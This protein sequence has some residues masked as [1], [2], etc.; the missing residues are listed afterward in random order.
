MGPVP[1]LGNVAPGAEPDPVM[2]A[3]VFEKL[4]QADRLARPADQAVVQADAHQL[5]RLGSLG[6]HEIER[7]DHV[8]GE[9]VGAAEAGI[10][11]EA[12][13]VGLERIGDDEVVAARDLHPIGQLVVERVAVV[14]EARPPRPGACACSGSAAR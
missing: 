13:V 4:D 10:A 2:L 7:V 3:G 6:V 14:E 11:V 12:V 8:A 1:V 5:R 9:I